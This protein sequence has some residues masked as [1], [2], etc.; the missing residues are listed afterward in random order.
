VRRLG[1]LLREHQSDLAE[2]VT[3]EAGKIPAEAR[4]EVQ[5]MIDMCD[6]AV[7]LS[8]QLFGLTLASER[9]EHRMTEVWQPLGVCAVIT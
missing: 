7:G 9:P 4:G 6:L 3:L 8:R 5:E 2:L 1:Q